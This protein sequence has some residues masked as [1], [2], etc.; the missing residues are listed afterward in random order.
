M[1]RASRSVAD[2]R[3]AIEASRAVVDAAIAAGRP[4]YGLN[5][6]LGAGRDDRVDADELLDFQRLVIANHRGGVGDALGER[7]SRALIAARLIGFT[8]GGSGVRIRARAG[9]RRPAERGTSIR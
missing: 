1:G 3:E 5:T 2:A 9:V 4:V 8:R 6:R 7:Q